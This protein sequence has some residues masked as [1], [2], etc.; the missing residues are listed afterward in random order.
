[1]IGDDY[2]ISQMNDF[3]A[4]LYP[5]FTGL[6]EQNGALKTFISVGGWAAGGK[7]FSDMVSTATYRAV[8]INSALQFMRTYGFDGIGR[9]MFNI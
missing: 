4:E 3:D 5:L 9:S 7:I 6:K 1:L 2:T 8:F